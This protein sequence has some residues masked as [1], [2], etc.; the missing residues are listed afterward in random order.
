MKVLCG[1]CVFV[2][3]LWKNRQEIYTILCLRKDAM[4]LVNSIL[5]TH[6]YTRVNL[7]I[8]VFFSKTPDLIFQLNILKMFFCKRSE[9]NHS[10][11]HIS[12]ITTLGSDRIRQFYLLLSQ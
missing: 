4:A 5:S 2:V 10:M 3:K 11:V 6:S 12:Y 7:A 1:K 8:C 9:C